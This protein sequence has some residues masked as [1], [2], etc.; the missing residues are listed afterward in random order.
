VVLDAED[1]S[2]RLCF[3]SFEGQQ[4]RG[5]GEEVVGG[6]FGGCG[7]GTVFRGA[8]RFLHLGR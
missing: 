2:A 4:S 5:W 1:G 8:E 7:E 6:R 3:G